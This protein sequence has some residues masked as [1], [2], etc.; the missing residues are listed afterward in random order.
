MPE[1]ADR[2]SQV[3]PSFYYDLIARVVPGAATLLLATLFA[4]P[5]TGLLQPTES[6]SG[7]SA[8]AI[9]A[10]SYLT[11][12]LLTPLGGLIGL[13]LWVL[14]RRIRSLEMLSPAELWRRIDSIETRRPEVAATLSK[15]AAEMT[16]SENLLAGIV[17]VSA[18]RAL[19]GADALTPALGIWLLV[20]LGLLLVVNLGLR[21]EVLSRRI[22]RLYER[23]M[24]TP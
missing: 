2:I 20:G 11:A 5:G 14:F 3:V 17:A 24:E 12:L 1:L 7:W 15:M 22:N 6:W 13:L 4:I 18:L 10:T 23:T 9:L 19:P 16:L 21:H 8:L